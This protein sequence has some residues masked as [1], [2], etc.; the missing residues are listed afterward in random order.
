[1][2][3]DNNLTIIEVW[4]DFNFF[5]FWDPTGWILDG[6]DFPHPLCFQV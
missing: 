6:K 3:L 4:V 5:L 2:I 1:M